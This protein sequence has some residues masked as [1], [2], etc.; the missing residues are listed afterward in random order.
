MAFVAV[1]RVDSPAS[2]G[3]FLTDQR[4]HRGH[5]FVVPVFVCGCPFGRQP[6]AVFLPAEKIGRW[7]SGGSAC[8][9]CLR[10]LRYWG[11]VL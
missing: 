4:K 8:L 9:L 5:L 1:G 6:A 2:D 7:G 11:A 3:C 10:P